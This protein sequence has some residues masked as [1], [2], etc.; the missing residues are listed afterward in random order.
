MKYIDGCGVEHKLHHGPG[1][2]KNPEGGLY[3]RRK[4]GKKMVKVYVRDPDANLVQFIW[5]PPLADA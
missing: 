4:S 2:K 5:H 1:N 3:Y